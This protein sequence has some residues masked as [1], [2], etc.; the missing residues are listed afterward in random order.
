[1]GKSQKCFAYNDCSGSGG[2]IA[3]RLKRQYPDRIYDLRPVDLEVEEISNPYISLYPNPAEEAVQLQIE[4]W[5]SGSELNFQLVTL[6]GQVL[7]NR[8]ITAPKTLIQLAT[9][10]KGAYLYQVFEKEEVLQSGKL[11]IQ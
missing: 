2:E 4:N 1:M 8:R 3:T 10:K 7:I 9:F 11:I 5:E 6:K